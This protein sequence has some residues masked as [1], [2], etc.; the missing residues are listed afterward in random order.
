MLGAGHP[1]RIAPSW[2]PQC[3]QGVRAPGQFPFEETI[4]VVCVSPSDTH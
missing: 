2:T 1:V 4:E 3:G